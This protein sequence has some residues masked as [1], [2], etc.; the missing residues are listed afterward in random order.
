M[1]VYKGTVITCNQNYDTYQYLIEDAG[2]IIYIGDKLPEEY[3]NEK[4]IDLGDKALIPTFSDNHTHF[5]TYAILSMALMVDKAKS[6]K[7][8]Q[9]LIKD[10]YDKAKKIIFGFGTKKSNVEEKK[11]ITRA[12]IDEVCPDKHAIIITADG[13]T[14]I[15]NS[16]TLNYLPS[17][18]KSIRGYDAESGIMRH[19][20]FYAVVNKLSSLLSKIDIIKA[21][22]LAIDGMVERGIGHFVCCA[23]STFP[24]DIDV[25]LLSLIAKGQKSG[26]QMRVLYQTF[27][28]D[29]VKKKGF[30]RL[31]GCFETAL[32]GSINSGDAAFLE[33]YNNTNNKGILYHT[34]E[35]LFEKVD[36]ANKEGVQVMMH[37]I[38]DAAFEQGVNAIK[39]AL[40]RYPRKDHRHG[41]IHAS[42]PTENA[43][44]ICKEYN[45]QILA[46]Y[47]FIDINGDIFEPM[48]ELLGERVYK[49]EPYR[50]MFD[51]NLVVSAGSDAPVT[52]PNPI[53][54]LDKAC[55]NPNYKN[56]LTIKEALRSCTHNG[57]YSTFDEEK[58]GSLE[59]GKYADMVILNQNPYSIDRRNISSLKIEKVFL[60]GREFK[61]G[62]TNTISATLKGLFNKKNTNF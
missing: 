18:L 12:E 42:M 52:I 39:Y 61:R 37:A 2:K 48:Y 40:D 4:L 59:V 9:Q 47:A 11:L 44:L 28:L 45:I 41:I 35:E 1:R 51:Y 22:Q 13:H 26:V 5:A 6:N 23:G 32:D 20:A 31:G 58:R 29:K 21:F 56:Q 27:D 62:T 38:G 24:K 49:A 10:H 15:V 8:I 14:L 36:K 16:K 17:S 46:Q 55:N 34:D 30:S 7:E 33:P 60:Q 50:K 53:Q 43:L 25:T 54:W 57:Y 19:E 3:Q